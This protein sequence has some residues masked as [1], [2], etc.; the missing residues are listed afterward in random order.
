MW[1]FEI[2]QPALVL[3]SRQSA[4]LIDA[5]ACEA[6]GIDVVTRRS[7]GG[8]MLLVPGEHLW[9]DVVIGSDDPLWS[10]DVQ[11]S[12][13]WLGEIWQRALAEV[14]VTDTQVASGGLVADELGQLVCFAGRGPGEVMGPTGMTKFVG[15]SQRRTRD[16]AR[17]QCTSYMTWDARVLAEL[18]AEPITDVERLTRMVGLVPVSPR[19]LAARVF[20]LISELD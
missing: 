6:R 19:V 20:E 7:G 15:I 18:L 5:Q 2:T 10:N 3:G 12:M 1:D 11:T 16:Q 14:G 9:L 8:L 4:S 17:F 13:A